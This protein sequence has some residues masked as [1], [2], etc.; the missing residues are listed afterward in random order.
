MEITIDLMDE[1]CKLNSCKELLEKNT[2][3]GIFKYSSKYYVCIGTVSSGAKGWISAT[4]YQ[5][6]PLE[7]KLT[8]PKSR[9]EKK[10]RGYVGRV[11]IFNKK[12]MI[13]LG[14]FINVKPIGKP[15]EQLELF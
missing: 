9:Y 10:E 13:M 8:Y 2:V 12:Q 1:L 7:Y 15:I 3:K 5:V 14:P 4:I 11:F 6:V